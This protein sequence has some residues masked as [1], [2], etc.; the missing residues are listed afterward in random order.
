M[1]KGTRKADAETA[2]M[3]QG[4]GA[5]AQEQSQGHAQH[6]DG[7]IAQTAQQ[8]AQRQPGKQPEN[9]GDAQHQRY[10]AQLCCG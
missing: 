5:A 8:V 1:M 2:D 4:V 10:G 3:K 7:R 6:Q 9:G